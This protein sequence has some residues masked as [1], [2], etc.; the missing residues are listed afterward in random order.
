MLDDRRV[1]R[2]TQ[3]RGKQPE[4]WICRTVPI[5]LLI[6]PVV[7]RIFCG[8]A[9]LYCWGGINER[10]LFLRT[11]PN[12]HHE[13]ALHHIMMT[14]TQHDKY[15]EFLLPPVAVTILVRI[16]S[17]VTVCS[18]PYTVL[19]AQIRRRV[20]VAPMNMM[21]CKKSTYPSRYIN[22]L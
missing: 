4:F 20:L 7:L 12:C 3:G 21:Q 19:S 1:H 5:Y 2:A 17:R 15:I 16:K 6:L 13:I 9:L 11:N 14:Y 10:D 8:S 18:V 22:F